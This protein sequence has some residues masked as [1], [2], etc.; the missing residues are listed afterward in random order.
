MDNKCLRRSKLCSA[1]FGRGKHVNGPFHDEG[2]CKEI[3]FRES[4]ET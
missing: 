4:F 2:L 1:E 3:Y